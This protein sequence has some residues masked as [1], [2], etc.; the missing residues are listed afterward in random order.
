[1]IPVRFGGDSREMVG[2]YHP[3]TQAAA[4]PAVLLC[5]PFGQETLRSYRM[6]RLLADRLAA[7]GCAVLRFDYF[8]TGDSPGDD[9]S[10]SLVGW[11]GDIGSAH[12][13]LAAR[14]AKQSVAWVGLR[15]G[16]SLCALA[17]QAPRAQLKHIVMWDPVISGAAYLE[18]LAH[19]PHA[20]AGAA[21]VSADAVETMGFTLPDRFKQELRGLNLIALDAP[22][23]ARTTIILGAQDDATRQ[24]QASLAKANAATEWMVSQAAAEWNSDKA[25]N[26]A[27]IPADLLRSIQAKVLESAR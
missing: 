9:E 8:G 19:N 16:A 4:A 14:S 15:L 24:W 2:F 27:A 25:M 12:R 22:K 1:M 7:A 21:A 23:V 17:A 5:H 11:A 3:P 13:E 6:L 10:A 20:H 18:S 26:T